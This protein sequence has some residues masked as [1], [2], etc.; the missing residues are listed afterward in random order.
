MTFLGELNF[1]NFPQMLC[2]TNWLIGPISMK[3]IIFSMQVIWDQIINIFKV[4]TTLHRNY[5]H[6]Y[7]KRC[8]VISHKQLKTLLRD[9][10]GEVEDNII[11]YIKT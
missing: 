1:A 2:V 5:W 11:I 9:N 10:N 8:C 3:T 7:E 6:N 4:A